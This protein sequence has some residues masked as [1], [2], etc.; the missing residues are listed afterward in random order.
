[1]LVDVEIAGFVELLVIVME[2]GGGRR[3]WCFYGEGGVEAHCFGIV[4]FV[5]NT[6]HMKIL[7]FAVS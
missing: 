1:M 6:L 4:V 3:R 7:L 5:Q 2:G